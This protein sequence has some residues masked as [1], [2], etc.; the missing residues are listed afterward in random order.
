MSDTPPLLATEQSNSGSDDFEFIEKEE[1]ITSKGS[2]DAIPDLIQTTQQS[3]LDV[4]DEIS[5]DQ[6]SNLNSLVDLEVVTSVSPGSDSLVII[7]PEIPTESTE[8]I[9]TK[10]RKNVEE[11]A[12]KVDEITLSKEDADLGDVTIKYSGE[13]SPTDREINP[14]DIIPKDSEIFDVIPSEKREISDDTLPLDLE[15]H[16][17]NINPKDS[18]IFDVIPSEKREISDDTL[19]QDLEIHP[20]DSEI[21]DVI[22]SEKR[23]ISDDTLTQNRESLEGTISKDRESSE[24]PDSKDD[25]ILQKNTFKNTEIEPVINPTSDDDVIDKNDAEVID[26]LFSPKETMDSDLTDNTGSPSYLHQP[27]LDDDSTEI[28]VPDKRTFRNSTDSP[29]LDNSTSTNVTGEDP[30]QDGEFILGMYNRL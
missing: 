8:E 22:P 21:F 17:E 16:P 7:E 6:D 29:D 12:A 3:E 23:E 10:D 11:T 1:G 15:I 4:K 19:P 30:T 27:P 2:Y 25:G 28:E 13:I 24:Q 14:E 20:E 26:I 18:E 5:T 9:L